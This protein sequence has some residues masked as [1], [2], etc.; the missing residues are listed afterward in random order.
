ME[1][2]GISSFYP[3][4][5][6]LQD[7]SQLDYYR[8]M[9][10]SKFPI[11]ETI[12]REH[13]LFYSLCFVAAVFVIKNVFLVLAGY[14]NI[15][16]IT[17]LYCAWMNQVF[18]IYMNKPYSFFQE[19]KAGDLVQRK[20]M[21]TDKASTA[22]RV[23]ILLLGGITNIL[24]IYL[25]LCLMSFKVT[26]AIT[27][28]MI[29]L[30][31]FTIR[32]SRRNIYKAGDRL[33]DLEKKGFGLT[34]EILSGIK[35]VKVFCAE[36]HFQKQI[37]KIWQEYSRHSIRN[38]F[39]VTLPRPVVETI[40]VLAGVGALIMFRSVYAQ[41]ANVLPT[42]AVFAIGLFRILPL[43]A[44]CSS[45]V[46][47]LAAMLP[48]AETVANIL[49]EKFEIKK[50]RE[51]AQLTEK[52][53][54]QNVSFSYSNREIVL[55]NI[56]LK[57]Q[58]N[59][60]YGIVGISGS[61]K[62]TIIDLITGFFKPKNGRI[63]IDGVNLND[64]DINT[65]LC[66][67]GLISQDTFIFSGT[68]EDNIC[69]GVNLENRDHSLMRKAA[70]IAYAD[71]FIEQLANGYQTF[72]GERGVKLSG[73]QRQRLAIARAIYLDPPVLIFDEA[74]SSLD[75]NSEK[76]VQKAIEALHGKRT[77]IVVAH[78]LGTIIDADHI[79]VI[80]NGNLAEEGQHQELRNGNGLYSQLCKK[81][82]LS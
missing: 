60:F 31:F 78:R 3:I 11:A 70:S 27:I 6:M 47:T 66:Q 76:K 5:E 57:F 59:N 62:S 24:G 40:V 39:L 7:S 79:Y 49:S 53:E 42:L 38:Q 54:L 58:K 26:M 48:S 64:A 15:V 2:I 16:V 52:F 28:F 34:T 74:T 81:Q 1:S 44:A 14:G 10:I 61:G 45:Q 50:G 13:F 55:K 72:V 63:L 73:G 8:N 80:E 82:S 71:E 46:M 25:V 22:L 9:L 29:P 20:I 69:F 19:N 67:I 77:V 30:Y 36:N 17:R 37:R 35:Q 18:Q 33:V 56:N 12:N 32:I 41:E 43:S 75:T 21:Q 23:F 4:T 68:V 65:W 51:L